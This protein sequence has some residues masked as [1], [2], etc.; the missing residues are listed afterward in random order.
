MELHVPLKG[1][2]ASLILNQEDQLHYIRQWLETR[3][4][5]A[6]DETQDHVLRQ[7]PPPSPT[8]RH[9]KVGPGKTWLQPQEPPKTVSLKD[10]ISRAIHFALQKPAPFQLTWI[11]LGIWF[12]DEGARHRVRELTPFMV[13]NTYFETFEDRVTHFITGS[14]SCACL[15]SL[16]AAASEEVRC[17]NAYEIHNF[18]LTK[19]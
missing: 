3:L 12:S 8:H 9:R 15:P 5:L 13:G 6:L 11:I 2:L 10:H 7:S 18:L 14:A 17:T 1:S 16:A 4:P 19:A